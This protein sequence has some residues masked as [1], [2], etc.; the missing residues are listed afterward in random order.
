MRVFY[1]FG[2]LLVAIFTLKTSTNAMKHVINSFL[3]AMIPKQLLE[4]VGIRGRGWVRPSLELT[5][6][7]PSTGCLKKRF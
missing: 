1:I 5:N 3:D 4:K 7:A 6:I 2:E